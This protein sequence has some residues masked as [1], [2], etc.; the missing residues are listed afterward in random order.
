[1]KCRVC[2]FL[3]IIS[4]KCLDADILKF[5]KK[6]KV[7][8]WRIST[9]FGFIGEGVSREFEEKMNYYG[10]NEI[11]PK[12]LFWGPTSHPFT[13]DRVS[14]DFTIS[15][16][17]NKNYSLAL[18]FFYSQFRTSGYHKLPTEIYFDINYKVRIFSLLYIVGPLKFIQFGIGPGVA[19]L[20]MTT[21]KI[22]NYHYVETK[23][24]PSIVIQT[25]IYV[26]YKTRFFIKITGNSGVLLNEK[27][28]PIIAYKYYDFSEGILTPVKVNPSFF[29]FGIGF[30][31]FF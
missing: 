21:D 5:D 29:Y 24:R 26:P 23:I 31:F 18:Y 12:V 11:S 27:F 25:S 1:M 16:T 13:A 6:L 4:L 17:I 14:L 2:I 20:K 9:T 15:F 28:G 19:K 22:L 8:R 7:R 10:F 3:I 30:G